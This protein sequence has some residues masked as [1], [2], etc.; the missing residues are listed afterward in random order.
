MI[1]TIAIALLSIFFLFASSIKI[2]GWQK[3]V[4]EIQLAMFEKYGLNRQLMV[5][6]GLVELF[7]SIAIWFQGSALGIIGALALL[8]TSIAALFFHFVFDT[9]K[10]AIP[11]MITFSLSAFV[12]WTARHPLL[13]MLGV[14]DLV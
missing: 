4:F 3:K 5:L 2:L 6:T 13:A 11:A 12:V 8:G 10:D 9:W 1:T 14:P 7:G